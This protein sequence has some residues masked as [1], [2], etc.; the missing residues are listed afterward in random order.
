MAVRRPIL[1]VDL[2]LSHGRISEQGLLF[3]LIGGIG[4]H[5][6]DILLRD[7][8]N[9][10]RVFITHPLQFIIGD[11]FDGADSWFNLQVLHSLLWADWSEFALAFSICDS[12]KVLVLNFGAALL[13]IFDRV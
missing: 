8:D 5:S 3:L 11:L 7:L 12:L 2:Q 13:A 10:C 9:H 6:V 4:S 1:R